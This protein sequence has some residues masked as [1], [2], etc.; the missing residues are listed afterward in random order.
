M[1]NFV[2]RALRRR[3]QRKI[4][5]FCELNKIQFNIYY[6]KD[7]DKFLGE[8]YTDQ[9]CYEPIILGKVI[10]HGNH[11]YNSMLWFILDHWKSGDIKGTYDFTKFDNTK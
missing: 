1:K 8:Y 4:T 3:K 6:N 7:K 11:L 10:F 9:A 2:V 5:K